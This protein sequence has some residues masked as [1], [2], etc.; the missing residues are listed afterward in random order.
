MTVHLIW[1]LKLTVQLTWIF[2]DRT[3][4]LALKVTVRATRILKVM[5]QLIRISKVTVQLTWL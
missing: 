5:G 2:S 3:I 4:Y 1:I